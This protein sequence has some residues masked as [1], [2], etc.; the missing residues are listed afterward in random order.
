MS[1]E[2]YIPECL[3]E[4]ELKKLLLEA[5][6]NV[7]DWSSPETFHALFDHLERE[8]S[9]DDVIHGIESEWAFERPPRFDRDHWQ[10][11]YFLA[12]ESVDGDPITI[13]V[14]VNTRDREFVIVTRWR[15]E[16]K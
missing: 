5:L 15:G 6:E 7:P 11:K 10:W 3:S 1:T 13:V 8:L 12:A 2:G 14:A 9:S 16:E 4:A